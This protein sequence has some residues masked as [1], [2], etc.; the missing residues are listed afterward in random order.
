MEYIL[1]LV[2]AGIGGLVYGYNAL[3]AKLD[4]VIKLLEKIVYPPDRD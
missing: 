2:I 3:E 1:A 4:R